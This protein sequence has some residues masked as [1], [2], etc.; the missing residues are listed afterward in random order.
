L[1]VLF[2]SSQA[3]L[4]YKCKIKNVQISL[5]HFLNAIFTTAAWKKST[6]INIQKI[7]FKAILIF[8]KN[9]IWTSGRKAKNF[10]AGNPGD[11]ENPDTT[12]TL[13]TS[14]YFAKI[15]FFVTLKPA[16]S[17]L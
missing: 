6:R 3:G 5:S 16:V 10:S 15:I 12:I 2:P 13:M 11:W 9:K 7:Q 4:Q 17:N 14:P 8:A 1:A